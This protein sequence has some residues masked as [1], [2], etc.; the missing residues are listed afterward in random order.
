MELLFPISRIYATKYAR[1]AEL[2]IGFPFEP[3]FG[4]GQSSGDQISTGKR[5]YRPERECFIFQRAGK[6]TSV[7]PDKA[8]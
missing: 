4:R 6:D 3:E 8:Q 5:H 1:A 7:L 2:R